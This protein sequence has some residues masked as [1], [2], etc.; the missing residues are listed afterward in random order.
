[1]GADWS[2][3]RQQLPP[4]TTVFVI[5]SDECCSNEPIK[6]RRWD[7]AM[8][9]PP[10]V[11]LSSS[12]WINFV[13]T[14]G[15][16][17]RTYKKEGYGTLGIILAV[18]L[19]TAIFHPVLGVAGRSISGMDEE[20]RRLANEVSV[21]ADISR[22]DRR[23]LSDS[24]KV[25]KKRTELTWGEYNHACKMGCTFADKVAN[26]SDT[27]AECPGHGDLYV[28]T[29]YD[30]QSRTIGPRLCE[31]K[32]EHH[33]PCYAEVK[34]DGRLWFSCCAFSPMALCNRTQTE[35]LHEL[36]CEGKMEGIDV[37]DFCDRDDAAGAKEG[38]GGGIGM[39]ILIQMA[40]IFG[41]IG[42]GV[43]WSMKA[44]SYNEGVDREIDAY[45]LTLSGARTGAN[46]SL[47]RS[48]TGQCKPKGARTY[49]ALCIAPGAMAAPGGVPGAGVASV[50]NALQVT[51]PAGTRPGDTVNVQG[52]N[53]QHL[54]VVIPAGVAAGQP[55]M[56]QL[57][58]APPVVVAGTVV[59][60]AA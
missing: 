14:M 31:T 36:S 55:F 21:L 26:D 24:F 3:M 41:G 20:R 44:R 30:L 9:Q 29:R 47:N 35:T 19:G 59:G 13:E 17:V 12:E 4:G 42:S 46:F 56:V 16:K 49:R 33:D 53:G 1:M 37:S 40:V 6:G 48:W 38:R 15:G 5:E 22:V 11:S 34:L 60:V 2:M 39:S 7:P 45:L 51:A 50:T 43:W 52:P 23:E 25:E 58:A 54:Q 18:V 10:F 57:P 8:P 27:L 28:D 32:Y